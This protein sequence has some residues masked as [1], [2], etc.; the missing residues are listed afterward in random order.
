MKIYVITAGEY[1]DYMIY[2]VTT[3]KEKAKA[4]LADDIDPDTGYSKRGQYAE[5]YDVEEWDTL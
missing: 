3:S 1:D 2:A 4:F 5:A